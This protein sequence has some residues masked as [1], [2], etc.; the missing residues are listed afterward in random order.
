M[1]LPSDI[2][3][4]T[5]GGIL[6]GICISMGCIVFM[7]TGRVYPEYKWVGAFLFSIGLS[8]VVIYGLNLYTGKVGYLLKNNLNHLI[9]TL[10]AIVGNFIGC[11]IIGFVFT[12]PEAIPMCEAKLALDFPLALMKGVMCGMLMFIAVNY[13]RK[14]ESLLLVFVCVPTFILAGFEHSIADMFYFFSAEMM[15][16]L[17]AFAF[18]G[19]I[20]LGNGIGALLIPAY[21]YYVVGEEEL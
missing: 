5:F 15:W 2:I 17:E 21:K 20:I 18:I 13:Y 14:K 4:W 10:V 11:M 1:G 19:T 7:H 3:K 9:M 8:T 6:A 16:S 12:Y